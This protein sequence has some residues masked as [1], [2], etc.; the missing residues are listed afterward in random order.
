MASFQRI[1]SILGYAR[2]VETAVETDL[3]LA[4]YPAAGQP[5][6][7]NAQIGPYRLLSSLG[8]GG[9]AEVFLAEHRH[10]GQL[11]AVKILL[12]EAAVSPD[13][14][15]RLV[16]EARAMARLRHPTIAEVF[17]CD[18]LADGTAFIAM[19]YLR[20]ESV[21]GWLE[22]AGNLSRY[23][24]LAAAIAGVVGRGC[25]SRTARGW[26]TGTSSQRT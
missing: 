13:I 23:P 20:G 25:R 10:L 1:R 9:T 5:F 15:G 22:R 11:R 24:M 21:R 6:A 16:T 17:E 8:K 14:V 3:G 26:S 4:A 18:V 12:P 19:E 7:G 2:Q